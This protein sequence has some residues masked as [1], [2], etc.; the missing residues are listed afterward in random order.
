MLGHVLPICRKTSLPVLSVKSSSNTGMIFVCSAFFIVC[1]SSFR[2]IQVSGK[3]PIL[4][5]GHRRQERH[6]I[7][8]LRCVLRHFDE[9]RRQNVSPEL[10]TGLDHVERNA[11]LP[12]LTAICASR[13]VF[14]WRRRRLSL[15]KSISMGSKPALALNLARVSSPRSMA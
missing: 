4:V 14:H 10:E 15:E 11:Q 6:A 3:P 5:V 12:T 9:F 7:P 2:T 1:G 13:Q 8:E